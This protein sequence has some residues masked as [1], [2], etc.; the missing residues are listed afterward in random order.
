MAHVYLLRCRDG[1]LYVGSTRNL[2]ARLWQHQQ[3]RGGDYTSHRLPVELVWA[4]E[5]DR[6]GDAYAVERRLNGWSHAKKQAV[7][8]GQWHLLPGLARSRNSRPRG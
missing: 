2:P 6:V 3:G 8:D 1:T 5:Y 4:Q 7:V